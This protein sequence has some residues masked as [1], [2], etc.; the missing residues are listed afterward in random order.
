MS[1]PL[2]YDDL[3][4]GV[5]SV[6][7]DRQSVFDGEFGD[8]LVELELRIDGANALLSRVASAFGEPLHVEGTVPQGDGRSLVYFTTEGDDSGVT[9]SVNGVE[10]IRRMSEGPNG[11]IEASVSEGT[12]ADRLSA[13]GGVMRRMAA[14]PEHV[15]M[16]VTFPRPVD[17]RRIIEHLEDQYGHVELVSRRDRNGGGH[18]ATPGGLSNELTD[19]QRE[20]V[21][22]AYLGGYFDWPRAST[23]EEIATAM[24]ITQP[25]FNRHLRTAERKLLRPIFGDTDTDE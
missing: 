18:S 2:S 4:Y 12:V 9:G 25:T 13:L 1:I 20:A 24:E 5:L 21:E 15:D 23:G 22:T 16:T 6:Y 10:S 8:L 11:R 3:C 7:A 14:G 19:R 17:V